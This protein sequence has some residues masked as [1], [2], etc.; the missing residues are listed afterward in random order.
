MLTWVEGIKDSGRGFLFTRLDT[1]YLVTPG[2]VM[3]GS[4][5]ASL[6][7]SGQGK[8]F[9]HGELVG[10]DAEA[11]IAV[12]RVSGPLAEHC[13]LDYVSGVPASRLLSNV[14]GLLSYADAEGTIWRDQ[15]DI[16]DVDPEFLR[17]RAAKNGPDLSNGQSGSL[18]IIDGSPAGMIL[19]VHNG[20]GWKSGVATVRR[21]DDL[22]PRVRRLLDSA[23]QATIAELRSGL[24]G[25][26]QD[27]ANLASG[28]R[29]ARLVAWS[30]QP[31]SPLWHAEH[32]L[33][34]PCAGH[35]EAVLD[36]RPIDLDLEL[37]GQ[38]VQSVSRVEVRRCADLSV[39][40]PESLELFVSVDRST[41][42][43]V[44]AVTFDGPSGAAV[45][46]FPPRRARFLRVRINGQPEGARR[47][48][49]SKIVVN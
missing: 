13:G 30:A 3:K 47:V 40:S 34:M 18:L 16:V 28:E 12:L 49:L 33:G 22:W 27:A 44:G 29:G 26:G 24:Q 19:T 8:P 36:A 4:A 14:S 38:R 9:G 39:G 43:S 20:G 46:D 35:W 21:Y 2:H 23:A 7:G 31:A 5:S 48:A 41:W 15:V 11:D 1:C 17:I 10:L 45:W 6:R 25:P 32:L 42:S 37:A